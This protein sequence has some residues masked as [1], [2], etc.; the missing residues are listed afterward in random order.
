MINVF[1]DGG[2]RGNPG[3]AGVGI[4]ISQ[5]GQE[6]FK[7]GQYIGETTNNIAEYK[8]LIVAISWLIDQKLTTEQV[9]FQLDSKLVVEQINGNFKVRD[10][11]LIPLFN[12][13]QDLLSNF[14]SYQI[15]HIP[16]ALNNRADQLV[17]EALDNFLNPSS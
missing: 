14:S 9:L 15:T 8:A 3:P 6:I 16:R 7:E 1:T 5:N 2:A 11:K 10:H 4:Y 12:Q 13:A 17:N